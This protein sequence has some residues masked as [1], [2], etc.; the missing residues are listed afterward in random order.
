MKFKSLPFLWTC[1]KDDIF[2]ILTDMEKSSRKAGAERAES[3]LP[4]LET[5]LV[6]EAE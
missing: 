1:D 2:L 3:T 4:E 6:V 5:E